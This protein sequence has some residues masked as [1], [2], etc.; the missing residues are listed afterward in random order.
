MNSRCC[1]STRTV[2]DRPR[3]CGNA[4]PVTTA[5]VSSDLTP[6]IDLRVVSTSHAGLAACAASTIARVLVATALRW[7][8]RLRHTFQAACRSSAVPSTR[9][10]ASP[11][12]RLLPDGSD[13]TASHPRRAATREASSVPQSTHASRVK[14]SME[15]AAGPMPST[16]VVRS[17]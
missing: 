9:M 17:K 13:H 12:A 14:Y 3:R 6:G 5:F 8:N 16:C 4:P 15:P 11:A 2:S 7:S 1:A 10:D